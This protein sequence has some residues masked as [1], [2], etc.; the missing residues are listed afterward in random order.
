M[1]L[2]GLDSAPPYNHI[3]SSSDIWT[4]CE[5]DVAKLRRGI[6]TLQG[7]QE[8]KQAQGTGD[9]SVNTALLC[10]PEDFTS[11]PRA[12]AGCDGWCTCKTSIEEMLTGG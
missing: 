7:K 10:K 5:E 6:N 11:T 3:Q 2:T 1:L 8:Y 9:S 4:S 12:C